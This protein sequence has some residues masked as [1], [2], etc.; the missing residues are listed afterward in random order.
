MG[1]TFG[2]SVPDSFVSDI[3]E[4]DYVEFTNKFKNMRY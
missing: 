1:G 2:G 4:V 3:M